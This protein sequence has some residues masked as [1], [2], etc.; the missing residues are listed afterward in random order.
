MDI[1]LNKFFENRTSQ[2][3]LPSIYYYGGEF[4][5]HFN[6]LDKLAVGVGDHAYG[7]VDKSGYIFILFR[8]VDGDMRFSAFIEWIKSQEYYVDS[9]ISDVSLSSHRLMV[10]LKVIK[11]MESIY[12]NFYQGLYS[13]M[14]SHKELVKLFPRDKQESNVYQ[15]LTKNEK[16]IPQFKKL[17]LNEFNT[18]EIELIHLIGAELD[19]PPKRVEEIF[20]CTYSAQTYL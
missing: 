12:E 16:Y 9:Y 18:S 6:R 1:Q 15:I 17:L 19:T 14:Y 4:V 5:S 3:L 2:Y 10:V 11:E 20:N 8:R 13:R 7:G